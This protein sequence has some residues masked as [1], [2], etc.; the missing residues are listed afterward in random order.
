[1]AQA[2]DFAPLG[3]AKGH[4]APGRVSCRVGKDRHVYLYLRTLGRVIDNAVAYFGRR[5]AEKPG[6]G[7]DG[8]GAADRLEMRSRN[9][10]AERVPGRV[11]YRIRPALITVSAQGVADGFGV[12]LTLDA[13]DLLAAWTA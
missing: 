11:P 7:G 4:D 2:H 10:G 6:S 13:A 1:V 5:F 3:L 8:K 12:D 9:L